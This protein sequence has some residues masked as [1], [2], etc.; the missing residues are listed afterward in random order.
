MMQIRDIM[1]NVY[2][3]SQGRIPPK[4]TRDVDQSQYKVKLRLDSTRTDKRCRSVVRECKEEENFFL[5]T[6]IKLQQSKRTA[7][8]G[9]L[10]ER[11]KMPFNA[12]RL[13]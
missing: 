5:S 1:F 12:D 8:L 6:T 4:R 11:N 2:F 9:R 3:K 7:L 10:S 13:I